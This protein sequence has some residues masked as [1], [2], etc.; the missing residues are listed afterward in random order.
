MEEHLKYPSLITTFKFNNLDVKSHSKF[1]KCMSLMNII[2]W[3]HKPDSGIW[4]E[5][6]KA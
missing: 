2:R 5:K 1:Y 6:G 3:D 4:K